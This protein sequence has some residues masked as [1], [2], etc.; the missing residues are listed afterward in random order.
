MA[1]LANLNKTQQTTL[2]VV[3]HNHEVAYA[4]Q[5]IVTLRDG[6]IQ[7]DVA[8]R[9]AFERDLIDLKAS[10]LGQAVL[11]QADLPVELR[12]L[13]QPLRRVLERV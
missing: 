13:A 11:Q 5:R 4:T 12:D 10:T 8:V 3:T 1:L 6:K 2:V 9:N 7:S